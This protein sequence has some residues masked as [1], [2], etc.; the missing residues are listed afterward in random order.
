MLSVSFLSESLWVS[1]FIILNNSYPMRLYKAE[2]ASNKIHSNSRVISFEN[3]MQTLAP[4]I[5]R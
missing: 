2:T 5:K 3:V 4:G 1:T